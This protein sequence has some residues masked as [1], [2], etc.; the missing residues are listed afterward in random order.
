MFNQRCNIPEVPAYNANLTKG[1]EMSENPMRQVE[2]LVEQIA[3]S[4]DVRRDWLMHRLE[5]AVAAVENLGEEVPTDARK[6]L[7]GADEDADDS[8]FENFPV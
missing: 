3:A 1:R 8:E 7:Q 6:L 2:S 5:E 4:D